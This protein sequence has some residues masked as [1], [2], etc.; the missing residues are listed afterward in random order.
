[1]DNKNPNRDIHYW[2]QIERTEAVEGRLGSRKEE[3]MRA[4]CRAELDEG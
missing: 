3:F 1:M 4:V 2:L